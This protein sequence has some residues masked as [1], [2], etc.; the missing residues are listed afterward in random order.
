MQPFANTVFVGAFKEN[1]F[2]KHH[3]TCSAI[4]H[5]D[6]GELNTFRKKVS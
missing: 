6:Y 4:D 5:N 1:V 3:I 2:L